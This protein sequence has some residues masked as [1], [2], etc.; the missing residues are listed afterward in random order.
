[1]LCG[2]AIA[3]KFIQVL[4][5]TCGIPVEEADEFLENAAFATVGDVVDLTGENRL[6]VRDRDGRDPILSVR[7]NGGA[8]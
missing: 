4:Y 7:R 3:W 6:I 8:A 2:A 5:E 1:M